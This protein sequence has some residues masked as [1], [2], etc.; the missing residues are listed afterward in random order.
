MMERMG[1]NQY[2]AVWPLT[3]SVDG[4]SYEMRV[5]FP[6]HPE[7]VL[8][9]QREAAGISDRSRTGSPAT[10][11]AREASKAASASSFLRPGPRPQGVTNGIVLVA[12][13]IDCNSG[14]EPSCAVMTQP[15]LITQ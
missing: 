15:L 4:R 6:L 10:T 14:R 5:R 12:V 8:K 2:E 3:V 9:I 11:S 13:P 1:T 7:E